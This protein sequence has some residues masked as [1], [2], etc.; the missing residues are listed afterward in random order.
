MTDKTLVDEPKVIPHEAIAY[1]TSK[2]LKTSYNWAEIYGREHNLA[3]TVAKIMELDILDGIHQSVIKAVEDGQSFHS[4]KKGILN[5]LGESGWGS[6]E[7]TDEKT[8]KK[9]TRLSNSR[10]KKVY[11]TN[12]TQSYHAGSWHRFA[13][14][15]A[16]HPYLR[17][18][19]GSSKEH[20]PEHKRFENLVLPVDDPFWET[21]MPMNGWGCKCWVQSLTKQKAEQIGISKSPE[22]EYHTWVNKSTGRKY[23][24]PKGIDPSFEYNVGKHREHKA[25]QLVTDKLAQVVAQNPSQAAATMIALLNDTAQRKIID[26]VMHEVVADIA[27]HKRAYG[28]TYAVGVISDEVVNKLEQ[29]GKAPHHKIIAVRDVDIMHALRDNKQGQ[30]ISLPVD[31]W[32]QLPEKLRHPDA[33]LLQPKESFRGSSNLDTLLFIYNTAQGKVAV[34]LDYELKIK[35]KTNKKV[36][37]KLNVIK[38]GSV[39]D[40]DPTSLDG[41]QVLW[42]KL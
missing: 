31:F 17:Y 33:V 39:L 14:N 6:F 10:L 4:F 27:E 1:I 15:K 12:K 19:L 7:Q 40:A 36:N 42:G 23:K 20:R 18:R 32:Q 24:V 29:V 9:I 28:N 13:A 16:T 2:K 26:K 3:F 22:I 11:A 34:K 35:D 21:H 41:W 30:S 38:T 25:L 37:I 5:R 8:G